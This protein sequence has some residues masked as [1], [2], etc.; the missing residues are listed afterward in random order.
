MHPVVGAPETGRKALYV[1]RAPLT[2]LIGLSRRENE[3]LLPLLIDHVRGRVPG[4]AQLAVGTLA[5]WDNRPPRTTRSPTT[6]SAA[7]CTAATVN[8]FPEHA[9]PA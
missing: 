8:A 7:A 5:V 4:T 6:P 2:R 9:D 3:A 1:N